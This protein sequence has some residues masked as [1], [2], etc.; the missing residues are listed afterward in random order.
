MPVF[1][2]LFWC[3]DTKMFWVDAKGVMA[4]MVNQISVWDRSIA[5]FP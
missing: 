4:G 1:S 2:V 3:C 5:K